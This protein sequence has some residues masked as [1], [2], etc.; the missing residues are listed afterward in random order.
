MLCG[1]VK[2]T[3]LTGAVFLAEEY[4]TAEHLSAAADRMHENFFCT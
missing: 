4:D 3:K 1:L 2:L